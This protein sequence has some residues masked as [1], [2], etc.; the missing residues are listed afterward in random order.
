MKTD[1]SSWVDKID[2]E[3]SEVRVT[4]MLNEH[5]SFQEFWPIFGRLVVEIMEQGWVVLVAG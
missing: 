5:F 1:R 3:D 4:R 2:M